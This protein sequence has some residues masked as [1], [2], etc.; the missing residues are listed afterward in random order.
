M[1][2]QGTPTPPV[3]GRVRRRFGRLILLALTLILGLPVLYLAA[4]LAGSLIPV[5][6]DFVEAP[7]GEGI[8]IFLVSN[9]IHVDFLVPVRAP[10]RDWSDAFPPE[11]FRGPDATWGHILIGWGDRGF[12]LETPTWADLKA[13]TALSAV[14]W[15]SPSVVHA[16]YLRWRPEPDERWRP[17][18]I[19]RESYRRLCA[20]VDASFVKGPKG[21][22]ILLEGKGYGPTDNFYEGIGSYHALNTCDLWT[23][24]GLKAA[25]VR[26]AL[27]SPFPQ[28]ILWQLP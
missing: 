4:A 18:R 7:E 2:T 12:Y 22:A 16:Q 8:E 14:F 1:D 9:G 11:D 26:T 3:P 17:L 5:H 15:P 13:S 24:R 27:W 20:F 6:R 23:N 25:G 21:K 19:S 28:G 10:G